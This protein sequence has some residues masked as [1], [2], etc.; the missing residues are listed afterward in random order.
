MLPVFQ[1]VCGSVVESVVKHAANLGRSVSCT[2]GCGACCRQMVP[3]S[4][5]EVVHLKGVV[6]KMP[7][8]K[9]SEVTTRFDA[10]KTAMHDAGLLERLRAE[11]KPKGAE[12]KTLGL[13][14]FE[15]GVA[16]PFLEDESCSIHP[17]RPLVCRE[18][19]VVSPAVN[20]SRQN[21]QPIEVLKIP[22]EVSKALTAIEGSGD[23]TNWVPLILALEWAESNPSDLT[24]RPGTE[25]ARAFFSNLT[26]SEI[27]TPPEN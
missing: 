22:A 24:K 26:R 27:P 12:Y 5:T 1:S 18:Y 2:A 14:Y 20:C 15:Q 8:Q 21:G 7:S 10:A 6:D 16:C 11:G 19:I 9:R 4:P 23:F 25:I 3:I 13:E 17:D